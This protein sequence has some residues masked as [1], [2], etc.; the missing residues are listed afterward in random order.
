MKK[1]ALSFGPVYRGNRINQHRI[2]ETSLYWLRREAILEFVPV[3]QRNVA[4]HLTFMRSHC[5]LALGFKQC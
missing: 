4:V 5:H 3:I 1:C 2:K